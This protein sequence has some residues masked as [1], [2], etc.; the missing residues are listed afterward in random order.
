MEGGVCEIV[1]AFLYFFIFLFMEGGVCE[2][3]VAVMGGWAGS[4]ARCMCTPAIS[5][6]THTGTAALAQL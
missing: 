6:T 5:V 1:V 3:V 4:Y 2:I